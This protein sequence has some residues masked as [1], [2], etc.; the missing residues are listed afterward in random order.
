MV[1]GTNRYSNNQSTAGF[2][3]FKCM[4]WPQ[5][6][7]SGQ[8]ISGRAIFRPFLGSLRPFHLGKMIISGNF[9]PNYSIQLQDRSSSMCLFFYAFHHRWYCVGL[10]LWQNLRS[11]QKAI[12]TAISRLYTGRR[13]G[14]YGVVIKRPVVRSFFLLLTIGWHQQCDSDNLS[15]L[16]TYPATMSC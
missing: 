11:W 8:E 3:A 5:T 6:H 13:P 4:Y 9:I 15:N 1:V 7:L 2:E 14:E 10:K 12:K 16:K